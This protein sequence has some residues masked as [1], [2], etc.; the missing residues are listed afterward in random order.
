M[1]QQQMGW[2]AWISW[3]LGPVLGQGQESQDE[4]ELIF[5]LHAPELSQQASVFIT[6]NIPALGQWDP[7]KI[8]MQWKGD[9]RWE[10]KI[11]VRPNYPVEYKYTQGAWSNEGADAAGNPLPNFLVQI[12]RSR[13]VV[14]ICQ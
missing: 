4:V 12:K 2:I 5:E 1:L 6:G 11:N 10:H 13:R 14:E 9:H 3:L 8:R 7:A